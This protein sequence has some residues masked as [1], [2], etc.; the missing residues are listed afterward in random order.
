MQDEALSHA[1]ED[2]AAHHL[3]DVRTTLEFD[4]NKAEQMI[5]RYGHLLGAQ[6]REAM[7]REIPE[8]RV[9]AKQCND[10]KVLNERREAFNRMTVPLAERAVTAVLQGT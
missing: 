1:R 2:M 10:P 6:D 3:I 7:L 5:R 8:L 4:L 9:F